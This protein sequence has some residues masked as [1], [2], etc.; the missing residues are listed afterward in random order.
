MV[1]II[2]IRKSKNQNLSTPL[3]LDHGSDLDVRDRMD[4]KPVFRIQARKPLIK[5]DYDFNPS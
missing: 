5:T 2:L 3:F 4:G 1:Q